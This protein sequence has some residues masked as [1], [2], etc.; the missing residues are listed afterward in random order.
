MKNMIS[1]MLSRNSGGGKMT[2]DVRDKN[3]NLIKVIYIDNS[4]GLVKSSTLEQLIVKG[5]LVAFRRSD[6][7]A[8]VG[9]DPMRGNGGRYEGPERRVATR[10]NN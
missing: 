7:W 8:K 5:K 1:M 2:D 10:N 4:A 3:M 6:G 9:R